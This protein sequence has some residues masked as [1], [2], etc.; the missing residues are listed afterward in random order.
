MGGELRSGFVW[1][2]FSDLTKAF[3]EAVEP[4]SAFVTLEAREV[5]KAL[6]LAGIIAGLGGGAS[7]VAT[8]CCKD[9]VPRADVRSCLL[10]PSP[11]H[12]D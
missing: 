7:A 2:L 6:A 5:G 11:G 9:E 10:T 8:T 4:G 1:V 3:W 12:F